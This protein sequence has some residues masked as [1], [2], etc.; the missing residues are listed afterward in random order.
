MF[1]LARNH[2]EI[3]GPEQDGGEAACQ[4]RAPRENLSV[5]LDR[6]YGARVTTLDRKR[7]ALR[8]GVAKSAIDLDAAEGRVEANQL[9]VDLGPKRAS[10][11]KEVNGFEEVGLAL[12]VRAHDQIQARAEFDLAIGEIAEVLGDESIDAHGFPIR[13]LVAQRTPSSPRLVAQ[14]QRHQQA[15]VLEILAVLL[16]GDD[17][18]VVVAIEQERYVGALD[19]AQNVEQIARVVTDLHLG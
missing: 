7:E 2:A 5:D 11:S 15:L 19:R 13:V 10:K 17:T 3:V 6:L 16:R 8:A 14:A 18:G 1:R 4:V 9:G 12:A